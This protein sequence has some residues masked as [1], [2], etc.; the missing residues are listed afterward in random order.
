MMPW[1]GMMGW[2]GGGIGMVLGWLVMLAVLGAVV[3]AVVTGLRWLSTEQPAARGDH[4]DPALE[5]LRRRYAMGE[6]DQE[7]FE[8]KKRDLLQ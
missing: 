8:A 6:I 1:G 7:E 3:V 5:V 2:G 4:G